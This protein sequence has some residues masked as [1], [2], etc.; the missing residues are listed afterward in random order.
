MKL[1]IAPAAPT[2]AFQV[3]RRT[4]QGAEAF[5]H[6]PPKLTINSSLLSGALGLNPEVLR[7]KE[8]RVY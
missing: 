3:T 6:F 8:D 4:L 5:A 7:E 2:D 1:N